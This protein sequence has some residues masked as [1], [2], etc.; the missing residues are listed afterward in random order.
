MRKNISSFISADITD[1]L[2]QEADFRYTVADRSEPMGSG[3]GIYCMNHISFYPSGMMP[4]SV[5]TSVG[6]D[7]PLITP[8]N[9]I[10]YN[11]PYLTDTDNTRIYLRTIMRPIKGLELVGEYT[12]DRKNWQKSYYAKSGNILLSSW[13][14]IIQLL[15]TTCSRAK[16]MK[17]IMP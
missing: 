4:G 2:T 17:T 9:Q 3:D 5:N 14:P 10:R 6:K 16:T 11:N 7:L 8:E 13:V 1:W 15:Q 12:Y